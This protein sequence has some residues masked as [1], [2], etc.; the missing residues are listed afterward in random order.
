VE[1]LRLVPAVTNSVVSYTVIINVEN[2]NGLL[3]PGM[4]CAVDFI[5]EQKENVVVAP[6]AALRY[7]PTGL[8]DAQIADMVFNAGLQNMTEEQRAAAIESRS[9]QTQAASVQ[10]PAQ[11][12][13][14]QGIV[15]GNTPGMRG[16][17]GGGRP[18]G[19]G[20]SGT[21]GGQRQT[22]AAPVV[23]RNLWYLDAEGKLAVMRVRTGISNGT[24]TEI[25][26]NENIEGMSVI[27]REKL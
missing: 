23:M 11:G 22:G 27:L 8:T 10:T 1:T 3:V 21:Q 5:V 2:E 16:G 13:G 14:I 6:N 18:G 15:M 24:N 19:T 26:S 20:A 17:P 7:Q 25:I 12:T 4:T 9:K